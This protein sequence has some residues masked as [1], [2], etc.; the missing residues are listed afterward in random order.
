M[1]P[2]KK[3]KAPTR[4]DETFR[5]TIK[6][7]ARDLYVR[8]GYAGFSFGD[9]VAVTGTT[10]ANVHHHFGNKLKLM[11]ELVADIVSDAEARI[12]SHWCEGRARFSER[13]DRQVDDLRS[14]YARY[15]TR[16][17]ERNVWSPLSRLRL[18]IPVL[19]RLAVRALERIDRVY[20][21]A[22]T[23]A[24]GEAIASGEFRKDTPVAEVARLVRFTVQSCAPMTQDTGGFDALDS[25]FRSLGRTLAA[26]WGRKSR[27]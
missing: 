10:R 8:R 18:D 14:F 23:R 24:V 2:K 15:N 17:G 25:L 5:D 7:V 12:A 19:G 26:A 3:T 20:D 11:D 9:I 6:A 16:P 22:L 21:E 27:G 4:K 1:S 13:L